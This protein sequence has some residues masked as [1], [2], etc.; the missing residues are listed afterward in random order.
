MEAGMKTIFVSIFFL[1]FF[2]SAQVAFGDT[3]PPS[4]L[5]EIT[6]TE[7]PYIPIIKGKASRIFQETSVAEFG[8]DLKGDIISASVEG[9]WRGKNINN[10]LKLDLYLNDTLLIDFG[11]Y[12]NALSRSDKKALRTTFRNGRMVEFNIPIDLDNPVLA[13]LENGEAILYLVGK[14]KFFRSLEL[15]DVTLRILDP[16]SPPGPEPQSI[17]E[18]TTMLLLCSGLIGLAGASRK[19]KS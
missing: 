16:P 1:I 9:Q 8:Y 7:T 17:P 3:I 15:G 19:F 10:I 11:E 12:Y 2:I 4:D 18:P 6:A 13:D 14:P 5:I